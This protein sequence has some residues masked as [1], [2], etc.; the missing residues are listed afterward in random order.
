M[1]TKS[2]ILRDHPFDVN[3]IRRDFPILSR[4]INGNDLV[5]LDNAASSQKPVPVLDRMNNYYLTSHANVHRGVHSL[6][7]EATDLFEASRSRIAT[8][9]G[10]SNDAQ[11]IFTKGTTVLT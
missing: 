3:K 11:V 1:I 5:Y 10:A 6:S 7:Q 8:F 2:S 9:I 4:T